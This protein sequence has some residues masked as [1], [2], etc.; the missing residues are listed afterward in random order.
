MSDFT[1]KYL[2]LLP[3]ALASRA[4]GVV[5]SIHFPQKVQKSI[6]TA[7]AKIAKI[8]LDEA[9]KNIEQYDTLNDFFTRALK[10]NARPL[11]N[12]D[13]LSPV[14]GRV[15]A[16]GRVNDDTVLTVKHQHF[17]VNDLVGTTSAHDW[18]IGSYFFII[19]LSPAN[20]HRIHSPASA[21]VT[22]MSYV[23]GQLLPVNKLGLAATDELFPSNERLTSFLQTNSGRHLAL[24]KVGATCVGKISVNYDQIQTNSSRHP[25]PAFR[26]IE[27]SPHYEAGQE[28]AVFNLG[29]TVILFIEG[30]D[31]KPD[32]SV[33]LNAPIK[34]GEALGSF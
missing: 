30:D 18:L 7:F 20:Y 10:P 26:A 19:Y 11:A 23:P 17:N 32:P 13:V 34:M 28:L 29:S 22:H 25:S 6:N 33:K 24:V 8:N 14:D 4:F 31:F 9:S 15:S 3:T 27:P 1:K 21:N 12:A 2:P 5:S 16:F